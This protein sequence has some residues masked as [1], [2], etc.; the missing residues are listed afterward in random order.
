MHLQVRVLYS[1]SS[2]T[3][4]VVVTTVE[5]LDQG[6]NHKLEVLRQTC[7]GREIKPGPLRWEASNLFIAQSF[8]NSGAAAR[9]LDFPLCVLYY[10]LM[11]TAI[12]NGCRC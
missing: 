11:L 5:R 2:K 8:S 10:I 1:L 3:D 6:L 4:H 9:V 7:L 12:V